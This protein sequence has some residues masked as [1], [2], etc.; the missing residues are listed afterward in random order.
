MK[1]DFMKKFFLIFIFAL[2]PFSII[3]APFGLKMGMTL[4]E[5]AEVCDGI[6]PQHIE[7]DCYYISPTKKHPLFKHYVAFVSE[8]KGLYCLRAVS[9]D[10]KTNDYG[11]EIKNAFSEIKERISKTYGKSRFIDEIASDSIWK[12]D[13]YWL[14]ALSDGAR[15]YAAIWKSNSTTQLKDDLE[16]V[17]IYASA[18]RFPQ[19]GWVILEYDFLNKKSV[20]DEQDNVF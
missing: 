20:E 9:D 3:A 2:I 18:Q 7:N 14:S 19:I 1:G 12:D 16:E 8:K 5:I 13:K 6:E 4:N 10:I 15:T 17:S 11:T